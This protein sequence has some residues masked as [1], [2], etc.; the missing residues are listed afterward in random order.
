MKTLLAV[1]LLLS[2]VAASAAELSA[3][4]LDKR[5]KALADLLHEQWEYT[6]R[7]SPEFASILGDKRYNDKVSDNSEA[8]RLADVRETRRF[9]ERFQAINTAG[10]SEQEKLNKELM[11][12]DLKDGLEADRWHEWEMPVNQMGGIHLFAAQFPSFL[13]FTSV[14]DYDDYI[15]RMKKFPV[16]IDQTIATMR[17]GMGEKLMPPKFLLEKVTGQ[18]QKIADQDPASTPF[19]L[20]LQ[21]FPDSIAE[22]DRARIRNDFLGAIRT[23][24]L[25]A[26]AK[27]AKFV[28]DEYAPAGRTDVGMWSLPQGVERYNRRIRRSTTTNMTADQIH[29]LGLREVARI[30]GEMLTIA[31]KLGYNDLPSFYK[32]VDQN[33]DLKAKSREQIIELYRK[34]TAQM[35]AKLP[36][37]F[38]RL[39]KAKLEVVPME[40][41]REAS[42]AGAD[43][44]DGAP[45]GSRP[46]RVN[47]NTS[48]PRS[49]KTIT[50]ESTAYHEGV[51]GHHMQISI[52][53][54]LGDL[55]DF[56]KQSNYTAY[57]EGWALYSE[58]LGKEVGFYHDPYNDFGRLT[59][60]MLRAIRL[61]VDSGLHAKHWTREQVVQFFHDHSAIDE[62]DVQSET[63]RY[64]VWPGQALGYKVGQLKILELRE[65]ARAALGDRF[66]L[67]QFHD[68]VLGAG[69][70]PM[71]VLEERID[72]WIA[73]KKKA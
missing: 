18:A 71:D 49:R 14:K 52:A 42:A 46:G 67:R 59:D 24:V 69:A 61:V 16:T 35:Y 12:R 53:Q 34:Y 22:A 63:D 57:V 4:D 29:Q 13:S 27:F 2:T 60:E 30:E 37:L 44:N 7:T 72:A 19:A 9:L 38:G 20:P 6:M 66:D 31:K 8:A 32:A 11:V 58:R 10:F 51:P 70:L 36:E 62:V 55:P 43:Y 45:D 47:V 39:P 3:A 41:F 23:S 21:K 33:P 56:R 64:I 17:K 26:Y 15:T 65:R 40:S 1:A 48:E 54:E 50:M 73:A 28:R 68:E 5:R 25:P